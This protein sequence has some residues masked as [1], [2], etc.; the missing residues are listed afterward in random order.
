LLT[1]KALMASAYLFY[2][3][4]STKWTICFFSHR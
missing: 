3:P 4:G 1:E 2:E